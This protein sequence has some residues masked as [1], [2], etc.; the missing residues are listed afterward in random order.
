MAT[1]PTTRAQQPVRKMDVIPYLKQYEVDLKAHIPPGVS[2]FTFM[3]ILDQLSHLLKDPKKGDKLRACSNE[4]IG[5]A[6]KNC[7]VLGLMPGYGA[8]TAEIYFIPMA[9]TLTTQISYKGLETLAF[10]TGRY[11]RIVAHAIWDTDDLETWDGSEEGVGYRYRPGKEKTTLTGAFAMIEQNDG[12]RYIE[13]LSA[14]DIDYIEQTT[15][16]GT[17][18]TPAWELWPDRMY[19]KTAIRALLKKLPRVGNND[20]LEKA[21]IIDLKN[22]EIRTEASDPRALAS[23]MK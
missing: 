3:S 11:R 16:K 22:D 21:M 17:T 8:D 7:C 20:L 6:V 23:G 13:L 12:V 2:D 15:R 9:M 5:A 10:R 19:R 1:E 4:S 14:A 18:K